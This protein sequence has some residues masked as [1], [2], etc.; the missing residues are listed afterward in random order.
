MRTINQCVSICII[1]QDLGTTSHKF[2][3]M[4]RTVNAERPV[5]L[6]LTKFRFP[7]MAILSVSHRIS[8]VLLFL[9][10]PLAIYMMHE[11]ATSQQTFNTLIHVMQNFWM[12]LAVWIGISVTLFHLMSG[13]RHMVMDL[14]FWESLHAGRISAY[15]VF[16]LGFIV[17]VLVG[18]WVW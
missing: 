4:G 8:G 11:A 17:T 12:R 13:I 7:P 14:G 1:L 5:N 16:A 2:V 3:R 18:V 15:T 10:T 6:D 9:F